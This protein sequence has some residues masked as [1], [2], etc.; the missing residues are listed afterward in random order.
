MGRRGSSRPLLVVLALLGLGL[1]ALIPVGFDPAPGSFGVVLCPEA[2]PPGFLATSAHS[3]TAGSTGG[4]PTHESPCTFCNSPNPGP[5][6]LTAILA[7]RISMV[8]TWSV[9][10]F[11]PGPTGI[12][13]VHI[14]QARAPPRPV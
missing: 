9:A 10:A 14:P 6:S 5:L 8:A 3:R 7:P 1:R 2:F 4:R 11:A 13:V 12:R